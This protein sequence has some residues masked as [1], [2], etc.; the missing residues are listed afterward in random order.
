MPVKELRLRW[1]TSCTRCGAELERGASAWWDS[2]RKA[3]DCAA[4]HELLPAPPSRPDPGEAGASARRE[5][6]RRSARE[7]RRKDA[8]VAADRAWREEAVRN[9][10]VL[11]RIASAMTPKVVAG[12]ESQSTA[13][14]KV[15][16]E[17][18]QA[19]ATVLAQCPSTV[20]LHDRRVPGSKANVDHIAVAPTGVY[21][22]DAKRYQGA[23]AVRDHGSLLRP[24]RR[25]HVGRRDC[26]K[27]VQ[28]M[29]RQVEVVSGAASGRGFAGTSIHGVLCF[30]GAEW[31]LLAR[32][33]EVDGVGVLWPTAL[34]KRLER[35]GPLDRARI[36]EIATVLGRELPP[37]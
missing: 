33:M 22:I 14:W 32:P 5:Y 26:T 17:G 9:R 2:D 35:P 1:P 3:A 36:D 21:V 11:G 29:H 24:D 10:P 20:V 16:A 19:V 27:L 31:S 34:A 25:L 4:C 18:E 37:A 15:G 12:P 6:E 13:A 30:V 7:Q 23:V 8:A 28:A